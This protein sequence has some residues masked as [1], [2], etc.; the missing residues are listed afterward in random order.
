MRALMSGETP[1]MQAARRGNL[2]TVR[3]LLE[4]GADP[5]AQEKN[6]GQTA[7]MWAMSERHPAVTEELVRHKADVN[8][9]SKNGSTALMFAARGDVNSARILLDAGANPNDAIAGLEGNRP[10][11]R[12][13]H[14]QAPMS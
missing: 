1:L 2:E 10:D 14:G 7:L 5:N 8:A 6:G 11:H 13:H 3:A 12:Q 9:R 4:G